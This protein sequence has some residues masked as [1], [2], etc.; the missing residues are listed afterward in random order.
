MNSPAPATT[1]A[2]EFVEFFAA[3]WAIGAQDPE[4]FFRH[5][6]QRMHSNAALIQP[7]TPPARGPVH[8]ANSSDHCSRPCPISPAH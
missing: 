1:S 6:E 5:F 8:Y 7:I 2:A 4:W 3:G